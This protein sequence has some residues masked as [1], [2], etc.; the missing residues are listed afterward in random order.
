MY[1]KQQYDLDKKLLREKN[2]N[3][4]FVLDKIP[5]FDA[6]NDVNYLSLGLLKS[7]IRYE[8]RI[9]KEEGKSKY[10]GRIYSAHY[11]KPKSTSKMPKIN[12]FYQKN[13]KKIT[14]L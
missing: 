3:Q 10:A 6:Y 7:K 4:R 14:H 9:K 1:G 11:L 12:Y 5:K 2:W 8:E 13:E